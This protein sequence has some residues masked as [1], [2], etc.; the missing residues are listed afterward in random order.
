MIGKVLIEDIDADIPRWLEARKGKITGTKIATIAGAGFDSPLRLWAL[1][2]G[3]IQELPIVTD[4]MEFGTFAEPFL[5]KLTAKR[6]QREVEQWKALVQHKDL[7]WACCSTDAIAPATSTDPAALIDLKTARIFLADKWGE[8]TAPL[9]YQ[10]QLQW[11]MGI[12]GFDPGFLSCLLAGDTE[13]VYCPRFKFDSRMFA[14]LVLIAED[15]RQCVQRDIPPDPGPGDSGL[16][17]EIVKRERGK[18][19]TL[20]DADYD[21]AS[22]CLFTIQRCKD[23][24]QNFNKQAKAIEE[25]RKIAENKLKLLLEDND[26]ALLPDGREVVIATTT[27]KA[28]SVDG[29]SFTRIK[30]ESGEQGRGRRKRGTLES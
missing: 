17:E 19:T 29:Y 4:Q 25:Q 15:F 26:R 10:I 23:E 18:T 9:G 2:T 24:E 22:Q 27:V 28:R 8:T 1:E 30:V 13:R 6:L 16:I 21:L 12:T 20:V 7:E 5:V 14:D 3:K 11:G